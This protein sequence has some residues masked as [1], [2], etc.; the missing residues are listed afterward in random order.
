MKTD[1][2]RPGH[3][4][5]LRARDGGVTERDGHTESAVD[6]SRLAGRPPSG[7]L[8]EIVSEE[9][10]GEMMRLPEMRRF[11]GKHNFVLTSIVDLKQFIKERGGLGALTEAEE[12]EAEAEAEAE[13]L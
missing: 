4:F 7:V 5:P 11:C 2:V 9:N 8:C 12:A 13:V 3:I 6:L 1:L 10:V